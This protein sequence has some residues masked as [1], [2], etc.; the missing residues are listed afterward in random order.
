MQLNV[1]FFFVQNLYCKI[2][3]HHRQTVVFGLE[4]VK[5]GLGLVL[6]LINPQAGNS[7]IGTGTGITGTSHYGTSGISSYG[8]GTVVQHLVLP[9]INLQAGTSSNG[10]G[11]GTTGTSQYGTSS[12]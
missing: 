12:N 5:L 4:M 11:T 2:Q 3:I 10:T 9:L 7:T 1:E 6:P 8:T